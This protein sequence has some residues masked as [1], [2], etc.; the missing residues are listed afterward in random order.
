MLTT[1]IE[2]RLFEWLHLSRLFQLP[3]HILADLSFNSLL[4]L[5]I[6]LVVMFLLFMVQLAH[7]VG[8]V[9]HGLAIKFLG[10][11]HELVHFVEILHNDVF[12]KLFFHPVYL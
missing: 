8:E 11:L 5:V 7:G 9:L 4:I 1:N 3:G 2:I 12:T 6:D 10:T